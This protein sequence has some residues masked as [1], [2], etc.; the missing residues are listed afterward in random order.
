MAVVDPHWAPPTTPR[1][2]LLGTWRQRSLIAAMT[3]REVIGRYRGSLIGVAWSFF[4][5]VLMLAVYTFVF[6][7]V[8]KARWGQGGGESKAD[9]AIILFAG[10][11]VHGLA[12]ECLVRAPTLIALNTNFVKKVV[13]PLEILPV[14]TLCSA[15][16]HGAISLGVLIGAMLIA[17]GSVPVTV[18]AL[19]LVIAPLLL[20]TLGATWALAS[21]GVY[22]RDLGQA[23]GIVVTVLLF[24]SPIFYPAAAVPEEFRTLFYLNPLTFFIEQS[25]EVLIWNRWP[26]WTGLAQA[27]VLG[28]VAAWIGFWWFQKTRKGFADVL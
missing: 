15:L 12:A 6:S 26:D 2:A 25:R 16:F 21:L 8:F 22:V 23:M 17:K 10:L 11:I 9:F 24:V 20:T 14:V 18:I 3:R 13:F 5:P 4:H 19:P 28:A 7:L 1:A 27:G